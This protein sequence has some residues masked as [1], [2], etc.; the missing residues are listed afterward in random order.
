MAKH[1]LHFAGKGGADVDPSH[2]PLLRE[3]LDIVVDGCQQAT[4]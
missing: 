2:R 4:P 3:L 1:T